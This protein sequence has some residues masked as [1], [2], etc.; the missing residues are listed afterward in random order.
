MKATKH[1]QSH[2]SLLS[3]WTYCLECYSSAVEFLQHQSLFCSESRRSM[4]QL[5]L[6]DQFHRFVVLLHTATHVRVASL[7]PTCRKIHK[8]TTHVCV[9]GA[10]THT[11]ENLFYLWLNLIYTIYADAHKCNISNWITTIQQQK[12]KEKKN[13]NVKFKNDR[14]CCTRA[15]KLRKRPRTLTHMSQVDV[16]T[17]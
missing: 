1:R 17:K 13:K 7:E 9:T 15:Q 14:G 3:H 2:V 6:T 5:A 10:F 16:W 8:N 12:L 11:W 4:C